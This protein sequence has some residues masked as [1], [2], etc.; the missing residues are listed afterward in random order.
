[1]FTYR[2]EFIILTALIVMIF[3]ALPFVSLYAQTTTP[4]SGLVPACQSIPKPVGETGFFVTRICTPCDLFALM[5]NILRFLWWGI[6]VPIATLMLIYSGFLMVNPFGGDSAKSSGTAKKVMTN[7]VIGIFVVF[8]AWL[9]IDTIIKVVAD[10]NIRT[11]TT[12]QVPQ[13]QTPLMGGG[14]RFG[15]WNKIDCPVPTLP[16]PSAISPTL[17][18]P[19]GA[20]PFAQAQNTQLLEG[21][22]VDVKK[23]LGA[24][25]IG[26]TRLQTLNQIIQLK[27]ACGDRCEIL[28]TSG[29]EG[30]HEPGAISH[31]SGHKVDLRPNATLN[32]FIQKYTNIGPRSDGA[33]QYRAP[34]GTIY[35][36]E[37]PGEAGRDHWDVFVP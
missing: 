4:S 10:Q 5:Q 14:I 24:A 31:A 19:G 3:F 30:L 15:P 7:T 1:M 26:G 23:G 8:F 21:A 6:S 32:T 28:V 29:T 35:A 2:K 13:L 12:G 16:P 18:T 17:I 11:T 22:G 37:H 25:Q 20:S 27:N 33:A 9:I 36:R 34:N